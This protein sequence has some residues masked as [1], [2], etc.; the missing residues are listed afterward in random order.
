MFD[1]ARDATGSGA[2]D[3]RGRVAEVR[4]ETSLYAY[5]LD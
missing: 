4:I 2:E 5:S 1:D 3:G